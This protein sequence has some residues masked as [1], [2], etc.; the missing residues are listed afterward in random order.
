MVA[1]YLRRLFCNHNLF[2]LKKKLDH[3]LILN[4][5]RL[6]LWIKPTKLSIARVHY[7]R[8]FIKNNVSP[9]GDLLTSLNC[10]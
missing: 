5:Y 3:S 10:P 7:T 1:P 4:Y 2:R 9:L 6:S 8:P